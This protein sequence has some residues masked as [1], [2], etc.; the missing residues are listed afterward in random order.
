MFPARRLAQA[1]GLEITAARL[2]ARVTTRSGSAGAFFRYCSPSYTTP[3]ACPIRC[4]GD[5][6]VARSCVVLLANVEVRTP[7]RHVSASPLTSSTAS[8]S[9]QPRNLHSTTQVQYTARG[10]LIKQSMGCF[11][12]ALR[13]G[14]RLRGLTQLRLQPG[15]CSGRLL[16]FRVIVSIPHIAYRFHNRKA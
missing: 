2:R 15:D 13:A 6:I 16:Y 1:Q 12:G 9:P 11:H 8:H 5:S 10:M 14:S 3:N 4:Y 7:A